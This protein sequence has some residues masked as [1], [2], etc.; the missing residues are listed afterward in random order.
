MTRLGL[1]FPGLAL[2]RDARLD[3]ARYIV[4]ID[5]VPFASGTLVANHVL[6]SGDDTQ[7]TMEGVA[8]Y[9]PGAP[10]A[11]WVSA[12]D[13]AALAD[14]LLGK[15]SVEEALCAHLADVCEQNAAVCIGTQE[16]RFLMNQIS[17][18]FRELASQVDQLVGPVLLASVLRRLLDEHVPIRNLRAITEACIRI[19]D[20]ER[21][22]DRMVREAR[23]A[24]GS[25]LAR[26]HADLDT[27]RIDAAVMDPSWEA[28]LED[29]I[30]GGPDGEPYCM[31]GVGE[32]E[33]LQRA[34]ADAYEQG[35]RLLVTTAVLRPHL[36]RHLKT[37][38]I[39]IETLAIEE[40]P[41]DTFSVHA[42]STLSRE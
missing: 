24:L 1:P 20:G 18:E 37:F 32:L 36:R 3:E 23:I 22:I 10:K 35:I 2:Q 25:R 30:R 16:A 14:A 15:A 4:D 38:G 31:P 33:H 42:V 26:R 28:E 34:F 5:E 39:R 8:G 9:S 7:I 41:L 29:Q 12:A 13:A 19:P 27:W 21:T 11:V 17:I 40:I 6:V